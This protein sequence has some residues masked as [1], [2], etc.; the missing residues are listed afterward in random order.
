MPNF[1][2][3][4]SQA[5]S[6]ISFVSFLNAEGK[7]SDWLLTGCFYSAVHIVEATVFLL[8]EVSCLFEVKGKKLPYKGRILHS[9]DLKK[10]KPFNEFIPCSNHAL[11]K[12]ILIGTPSIFDKDYFEAYSDLEEL[13]HKSRYDCYT[14]CNKRK[15]RAIKKLNTI[16][17]KFN[18]RKFSGT[19]LATI[20]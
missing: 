6:N 5:A 12:K 4:Q 7:F 8:P 16:I 19:P 20:E 14:K 18:E 10:N 1:E 3:H 17:K 2:Q 13:S 15:E 11:R 9:D